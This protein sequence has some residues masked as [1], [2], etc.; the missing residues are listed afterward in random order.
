LNG[1]L[2]RAA[3]E[4]V[5]SYAIQQGTLA[6][7]T[8]YNLTF[9]PA[10]L[11]I[12][13]A[14][15]ATS[16][17]SSQNPARQGSSVTFTATVDPVLPVTATPTGNIQFYTNNVACSSAVGLVNGQA[18]LDLASLP[19]GTNSVTAAYLGEMNFIGSTNSLA[20]V[21]SPNAQT[22]ST[23]GLLDN[24]DG[25]VT[26]SFSGTPGAQYL[27]Q[28]TTSLASPA[29][30]NV[31]TNVAGLDGRWTFTDSVASHPQNFYR[32]AIP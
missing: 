2:T 19:T 5:G 17:V 27:V 14:N 28:S 13:A 1:N 7:S 26:I 16:L 6:A 18:A 29:W 25:T 30:S 9:V 22:P 24:G 32:S 31:S 8:N 3:G 12:A 11:T 10:D 4:D 23:L 20:Q 15:S 21:V